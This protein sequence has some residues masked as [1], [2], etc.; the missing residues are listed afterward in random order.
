M[1]IIFPFVNNL[2]SRLSVI[3]ALFYEYKLMSFELEDYVSVCSL[4]Q[5][6]LLHAS[7]VSVGRFRV[8]TPVFRSLRMIRTEIWP[9][10]K[11]HRQRRWKLTG[12]RKNMWMWKKL[13]PRRYSM[14][15]W[16][17]WCSHSFISTFM[18]KA[19]C[20]I[21][22]I[23][24]IKERTSILMPLI[25]LSLLLSLFFLTILQFEW[26]SSLHICSN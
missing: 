13:L 17:Q 20:S 18:S 22:L 15:L 25:S 11:Q 10:W 16:T 21:T 1:I 12:R 2:L 6:L 24:S 23:H 9:N 5:I 8:Q 14:K 7:S 26:H 19:T 3:P 4:W